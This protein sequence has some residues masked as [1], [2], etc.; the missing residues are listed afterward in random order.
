LATEATVISLFAA[1][2]DPSFL[3]SILHETT[4]IIESGPS[5]MFAS[6]AIN[7][8]SQ[9]LSAISELETANS[10][11]WI[12]LLLTNEPLNR[13]IVPLIVFAAE[14]ISSSNIG[15][16]MMALEPLH[17]CLLSDEL[18]DLFVDLEVVEK[19]F[20][21]PFFDDEIPIALKIFSA[22]LNFFRH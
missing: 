11:L 16:R 15:C 7:F 5:T 9:L 19:M 2:Q 10:V 20:S 14:F 13:S 21:R 1:P 18:R 22:F 8:L 12:I 6:A 4:Q 17:N 3:S